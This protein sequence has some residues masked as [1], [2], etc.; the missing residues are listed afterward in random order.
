MNIFRILKIIDTSLKQEDELTLSYIHGL[1]LDCFGHVAKYKTKYSGF[2][3]QICLFLCSLLN[4]VSLKKKLL[5]PE[6]AVLVFA[7]TKNQYNSLYPTMRALDDLA[8]SFNLISSREV[9]RNSKDFTLNLKEFLLVLYVFIRRAYKLYFRLRKEKKH[10]GLKLFFSSYCRNYTYLVYFTSTLLKL[11]SSSKLKLVV[12][13]NDHNNSNRCLRLVCEML[14]IKT[15]YM[16][17]ASVS[18]LFPPLQYDYA[19]LDGKVAFET[20]MNCLSNLPISYK[21]PINIFLSGQKKSVNVK[22]EMNTELFDVGI[23]VN[24]LDDFKFLEMLIE[25]VLKSDLTV[26]VRTHPRQSKAFLIQLSILTEGSNVKWCN[27]LEISLSGFFNS[28]DCLIAANSS[29]HL[30]AALAG[31]ATLYHE[32]ESC[33]EKPDYYGY[34]KNELVGVL[35]VE[36]IPQSISERKL[37]FKSAQHQNAIKKYSATYMTCWEYKE[38]ELSAKLIEKILKSEKFND[39]FNLS[40]THDLYNLYELNQI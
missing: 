2:F 17:H 20:Y 21:Y 38:G 36:N 32:F 16:Q 40:R 18:N 33:V 14:N 22:S 9:D 39:I 27:P 19:L 7:G 6:K 23:A 30:E 13:S 12:M 3:L 34:I 5:D 8:I 24:A 11:S 10:I 31:V 35:N 28:I 29:I 26:L 25:D 1:K 15:L 4:M 37:H